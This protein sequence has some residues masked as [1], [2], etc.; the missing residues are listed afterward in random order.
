MPLS[1]RIVAEPATTN[2]TKLTLGTLDIWYSYQTPIG[3]L[4]G[5]NV[6]VRDV[7]VFATTTKRHANI[8][9]PDHNRRIAPDEF[10]ARLQAAI[11]TACL[12]IR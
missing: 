6:T 2:L 1:L 9:E 10:L 7:S 12:E 5:R 3:F 8:I 4:V 11:V